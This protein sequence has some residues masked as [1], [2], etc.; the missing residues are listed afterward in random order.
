MLKKKGVFIL[1]YAKGYSF[2]SNVIDRMKKEQTTEGGKERSYFILLLIKIQ[3]KEGVRWIRS[4]NLLQLHVLIKHLKLRFKEDTKGVLKSAR[5][6][7]RASK[8][9]QLG[10]KM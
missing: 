8:L 4:G 1:F 3:F 7:E 10:L 6:L 2:Q 5:N 9:K